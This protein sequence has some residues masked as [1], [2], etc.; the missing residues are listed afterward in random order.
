MYIWALCFKMSSWRKTFDEP[1]CVSVF[2]GL[3]MIVVLYVYEAF[4]IY[5]GLSASGHGL[6]FRAVCYG[7]LTSAVFATMELGFKTRF[8]GDSPSIGWR[9]LWIALELF[10]LHQFIFLLFNLFWQWGEWYWSGYFLLL[11]E[12]IFVL[13][14]VLLLI[15]F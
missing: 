6:F 7:L 13:L 15:R 2:T 11:S 8:L 3:T 4:N 12:L 14:P 9:S 1:L 5:Q 10:I